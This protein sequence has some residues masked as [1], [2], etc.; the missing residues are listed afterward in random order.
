MLYIQQYNM[1][2]SYNKPC[3]DCK[4]EIRMD[5]VNGKWAAYELDGTGFHNC[6]NQGTKKV[7]PLT[8]EQLDARLRKVEAMFNGG[9]QDKK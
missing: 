2:Q 9:L 8:L 3:R 1:S 7:E 4:Q 5:Q 6:K